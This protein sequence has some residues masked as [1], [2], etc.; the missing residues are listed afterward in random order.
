MYKRQKIP[1]R[2]VGGI[3]F[4]GLGLDGK[5]RFDIKFDEQWQETI[6]RQELDECKRQSKRTDRAL[7]ALNLIEQKMESLHQKEPSPDI[8]FIAIPKE[9]IKVCRKPRQKSLKITLAH[10]RFSSTIT[11]EQMRGDYDFHNIIKVIGMKYHLTTQVI[12]PPTLDLEKKIGV[13]DLAT[14]AWNYNCS[15]IL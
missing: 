10:R 7:Y 11:E 4:P 6:T 1:A 2:S 8:V 3:D 9:I 12:L 5:L 14:R 15:H 13:Q